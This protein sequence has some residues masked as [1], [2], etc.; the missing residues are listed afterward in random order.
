MDD[1]GKDETSPARFPALGAILRRARERAGISQRELGRRMG[2]SW[3]TI[4]EAERGRDVRLSTLRRYRLAF[5]DLTP[6]LLLSPDPD[7]APA[8]DAPAWALL[9]ELHGFVAEAVTKVVTIDARG[10]ARTRIEARCIQPL[11]GDLRDPAFS[12]WL[13]RTVCMGSS[14]TLRSILVDDGVLRRRRLLVHRD[15]ETHSFT[16]ALT[17]AAP[18]LT[19]RFADIQR[20]VFARV[21][22]RTPP[23]PG[24]PAIDGTTVAV[25]YP[26][27]LV[28]VEVRFERRPVP[29]EA[30]AW[31][32]PSSVVPASDDDNLA[33]RLH[34]GGLPIVTAPRAVT[35]SALLPLVGMQYGMSWPA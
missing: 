33:G 28:R 6:E 11:R 8:T 2:V 9:L 14:A 26:T 23:D 27:R 20:R 5:P 13:A 4:R 17:D 15:L 30:T 12:T 21:P 18:S 35:M 22:P 34:P 32:L 16:W 7:A 19:Y 3:V 10:D 25:G 29:T 31:V 1:S 24:P